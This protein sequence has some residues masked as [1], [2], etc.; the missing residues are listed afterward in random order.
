MPDKGT[1]KCLSGRQATGLG[2]E[3]ILEAKESFSCTTAVCLRRPERVGRTSARGFVISCKAIPEGRGAGTLPSNSPA[4]PALFSQW[5]CPCAREGVG[6]SV[7]LSE[8]MPASDVA[9]PAG[10]SC[11]KTLGEKKNLIN[12]PFL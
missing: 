7:H 5:Q 12:V 3:S 6:E 4:L 2:G 10:G 11:R 1:P 9:Y 8:K